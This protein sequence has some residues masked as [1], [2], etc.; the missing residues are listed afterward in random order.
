MNRL[1]NFV[2]QLGLV[3][4]VIGLVIII[5]FFVFLFRKQIAEHKVTKA[6]L[7]MFKRMSES[8]PQDWD[9]EVKEVYDSMFINKTDTIKH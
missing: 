9:T 6:K 2:K 5:L 4:I 7:E 8:N 3:K 1:L